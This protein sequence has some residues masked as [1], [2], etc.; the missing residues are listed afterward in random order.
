MIQN[1]PLS[2]NWQVNFSYKKAALVRN[3]LQ[4]LNLAKNVI[5]RLQYQLAL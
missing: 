1:R 5:I 3:E 4:Q 2:Y